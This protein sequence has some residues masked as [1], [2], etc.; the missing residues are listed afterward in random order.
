MTKNPTLRIRDLKGLG[1]RSEEM[2]ALVGIRT[3]EKF[4]ATDP[5]V[6][7]AKLKPVVPGLNVVAIYALIGAQEN[8]H[9]L[10]VKREL[11]GEILLRLDMMGLT[12]KKP[13]RRK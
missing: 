10:E 3:V 9:W 13:S 12:S 6:L 2:F 11:R 7:Y 5:Y 8:R 1:P 4:L